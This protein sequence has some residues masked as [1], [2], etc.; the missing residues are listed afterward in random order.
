MA[1]FSCII[2]CLLI[3][4]EKTQ[5]HVIW[6]VG[7]GSTSHV[8]GAHRFKLFKVRKNAKIRNRFSQ[9][10]Y[11]T[12]DTVWESD[13]TQQH[14]TYRRA[15]KTALSQQVTIMLQDT[16]KTIWQRQI[17][18]KKK[19][20]RMRYRLGTVSK[21][22]TGGLKLVSRYQ[23]NLNSEQSVFNVENIIISLYPNGKNI[24]RCPFQT[25]VP[26]NTEWYR[27]EPYFNII[28]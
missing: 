21:K 20:P 4:P 23:P 28:A 2:I 14:A 15:K 24:V 12:Q 13:K 22:I 17:Q 25:S 10:P 1:Y 7:Y 18:I 5:N 26:L 19:D 6:L 8:T 16:D 3:A 11:L 27:I 9:V